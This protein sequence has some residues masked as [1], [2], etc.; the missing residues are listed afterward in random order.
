MRIGYVCYNGFCWWSS[1]IS[2]LLGTISIYVLQLYYSFY[3]LHIIDC[4]CGSHDHN[5]YALDY[6]NHCC[7]YKIRCGGSIFGAPALDE[8]VLNGLLCGWTSFLLEISAFFKI[9]SC[10]C[11]FL[12]GLISIS[13]T[14]L[15]IHENDF[16]FCPSSYDFHVNKIAHSWSNFFIR[17]LIG[18]YSILHVII[19]FCWKNYPCQFYDI[20]APV[21][22]F[23][24]SLSNLAFLIFLTFFFKKL[25]RC[26]K[27][28]MW[29]PLV[30]ELQ[31]YLSG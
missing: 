5:L 10:G 3:F 6:E 24:P 1:Q 30:A 22:D 9:L 31:H 25:F 17:Y 4:R 16:L 26:M 15:E 2:C 13:K 11:T 19:C 28:S 21:T 20:W 12:K 18:D 7:A 29:H 27:N 14:F 23:L 8:V